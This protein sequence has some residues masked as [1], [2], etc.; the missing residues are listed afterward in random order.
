MSSAVWTWLTIAVAGY[1]VAAGVVGL[2]A[3]S[4]R[5]DE[6]RRRVSVHRAQISRITAKLQKG[7][8]DRP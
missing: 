8:D 7:T 6:Y 3:L 2:R 1:S 5:R 4:V